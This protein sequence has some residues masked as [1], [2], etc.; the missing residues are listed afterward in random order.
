MT[1]G[2]RVPVARSS[3]AGSWRWPGSCSCS[4]WAWAWWPTPRSPS[5]S[6]GAAGFA[7]MIACWGTGS[8]LGAAPAGSCVRRPNP[9]WLVA[10]A[11]GIAAAALV[12]S[13]SHRVRRSSSSRCSSMGTTD[14]HHDRRRDRHHAARARP[15]R[16]GAVRWPGSRPL[17][18]LGLAFAY[19][20]AG[21]VL[22][23]RRVHRGLSDRWHLAWPPPSCWC[24]CCR[25]QHVTP[26]PTRAPRPG[27]R[28][29][30][31]DDRRGPVTG[32]LRAPRRPGGS[33][34]RRPE[35]DRRSA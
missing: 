4:G 9:S 23:A 25:L 10:G 3:C 21:P 11:L 29:A 22:T 19:L 8:V 1:A 17:L 27:R 33:R 32:V 31:A 5:T 28:D 6:G 34:R 16:S 30:R 20:L 18:S 7:S 13:G 26:T 15:T 2:L 14:G 12:A 35:S 24:C